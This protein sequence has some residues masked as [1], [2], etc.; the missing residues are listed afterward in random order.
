MKFTPN[1]GMSLP[2]A[3]PDNGPS[4]M[5]TGVQAFNLAIQNQVPT[6]ISAAS[7]APA[8]NETPQDTLMSDSTPDRPAVCLLAYILC[9]C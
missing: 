2:E 6:P 3:T 4:T 7:P 1:T 8:I 9:K 5:S